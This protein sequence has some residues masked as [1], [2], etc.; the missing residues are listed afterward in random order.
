[1]PILYRAKDDTRLI[2]STQE[3]IKPLFVSKKKQLVF[4]LL[5]LFACVFELFY[6]LIIALSPLP[7]LHLS[8]SPLSTEWTWTLLPSQLLTTLLHPLMT[9]SS[10]S[11][12]PSLLLGILFTA[13]ATLYAAAIIIIYRSRHTMTRDRRY[14]Y[15]LLGGTV[16]FGL[17]LLLQ[18]MLF[19]DDVF[20]YIF[21]GRILTIYGADPLNTAPFQFPHD[22]FIR[23][24][25][26]GRGSPNIY[27]PL[28]LCIASLLVSISNSPVITL[29]I[30][31]ATAL[32]AHLLNIVLI[33]AILGKIAPDRRLIGTLLYAWNPLALIEL[34]G[35]GHSEGVLL[36]LLL[37]AVLL[38]VQQQG[39]WYKFAALIVF[40]LAIST[41]LITLLLAPLY[42]WFD[43]RS[44]QNIV[45]V[46]WGFAWRML[47]MLIPALVISLP[48]W[49]GS[50]TFFA[51]TSAVDLNHFV[52]APVG[53]LAIP[54]RSLF[55][56]VAQWGHFPPFL[57]PVIAADTTLRASAT[58]IFILI[59]THLFGQVRHAPITI[60]GMRYSP[61]VDH[62]M[63]LPGFGVLLSSWAIGVFWYMV[64]VSGWFWPWYVLW[65]FWAIVLRRLDAF[66]IAMLIL[67]ETAL[68]LYPFVGFTK[69][70]IATY[71]AALIF[72][73]P[74][75]YLIIATSRQ[76]LAAPQAERTADSYERGS[77]T[78]QD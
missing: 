67:T 49:R 19:S 60:A 45:R 73:L 7:G 11:W 20:T 17:T 63:K 65:L 9:P 74:L 44:E 29:L 51:I 14:L 24:V 58:F 12:L 36:S 23:W 39:R 78:A 22:P 10:S 37:L 43:L 56:A 31:K 16:I 57:H 46:F 8:N 70:P 13:A 55:V 34:A 66:T 59:Y 30:F 21:S 53:T 4:P 28:W 18:P 76:K 6:L 77:E 27:G 61:D 69:D 71:Q 54:I 26:S 40:G 41:N 2:G 35:S 15:L 47:V 42:S 50:S 48:F 25:I 72:G 1:M 64:L 3:A 32:L 62:E 75:I 38:S 5:L 68:F 33:W 52:H